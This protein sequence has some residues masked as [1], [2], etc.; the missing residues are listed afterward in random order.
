MEVNVELRYFVSPFGRI[1]IYAGLGHELIIA[2]PLSSHKLKVE[3]TNSPDSLSYFKNHK[4]IEVN[5]LNERIL[6]ALPNASVHSTNGIPPQRW[7]NIVRKVLEQSQKIPDPMPVAIKPTHLPAIFK[8]YTVISPTEVEF[9]GR[10]FI[11]NSVNVW[12]ESISLVEAEAYILARRA[13]G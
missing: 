7:Q 10:T 9:E 1:G 12:I 8:D 4:F 13:L 6:S 5:G 11:K 2:T 3:I